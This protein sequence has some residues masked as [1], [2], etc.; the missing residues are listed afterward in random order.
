MIND[1]FESARLLLALAEKAGAEEAEVFGLEARSVDVDLRRDRAEMA[2]ESRSRGLGLRAVL[3][4]AVGFSSTSDLSKLDMVAESAVRA[5]RARGPDDKWRSLPFPARPAS[6]EGVFDPVAAEMGPE[7]CL[8]LATT[9]I[10]GAKSIAGTEP[11]SGGVSVIFGSELLANSSGLELDERGT[12]FTAYIETVARGEDGTVA[13]G[14]DFANSRSA[15]ADLGDVGRSASDLARRSLGG[16]RA[17]SGVAEVILGPIAFA[18]ILDNAFIPSTFA[19]QVQKGRSSL[20]GKIGEAVAIESLK[21]IDDG[22]LSGGMASSSFDGEGVPSQRTTLVEKGVLRAY[23]YDSY[24]AGKEA[25]ETK[26][27]GNAD[28]PGYAGIPRIG[29]TN[30]VATS[31]DPSNVLAETDRGYLVTGV[32]GAHTANPVSGDF[33]VEARNVF[34]VEDG[35]A[36]KPIRSLMLAGNVFDLLSSIRVGTDARMVGS[37]VVPTV[38]AEMK[39][40]GS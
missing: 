11:V 24:A 16:G 7:D 38:K 22:L 35:A 6:P 5:A 13:T 39:V 3:R 29:T 18:D 25:E 12:I 15:L 14:Y 23:L 31:A 9:L 30:V 28:R 21:I 17:E 20:A 26:S 4:G 32:I 37:F 2:S 19:D 40:V 34:V 27:T 10:A 1:L 33:S 8:D 36:Q